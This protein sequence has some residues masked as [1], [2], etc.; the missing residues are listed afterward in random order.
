M[1]IN[2][3]YF[4][5]E[6]ATSFRRNWVMTFGGIA[7]I[8]LSLLLMGSALLMNSLVTDMVGDIESRINIQVWI[9]DN[10]EDV[11]IDGLQTI[12]Q[13]TENVQSVHLVSKDE[14][15]QRFTYMTQDSPEI[16]EQ[17]QGNPLPRSLEIELVDTQDID[18]VLT[19]IRN[20]EQFPLVA[21]PPADPERALSYG[22]GIVESLLSATQTAR[23]AGIALVGILAVVSLIFINNTIRLAIYARRNELS[24]MRLVGASNGFIRAPFILEGILQALVGA[25]LAILVLLAIKSFAFPGLQQTLAFIQ[26]SF[27]NT[28]M[29]H[30]ALV[31]LV[32][33]I[34]IG[35]LGAIIAMRKYLKI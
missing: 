24:I 17:L 33:G 1:S 35:A 34:I 18:S 30:I 22:Q 9:N 19:V 10:A 31:L 2:V 23:Y 5:S 20:S 11:D 29:T 27:T 26:F 25:I 4:I 28:L 32:S 16:V 15:L 8:F 21:D 13:N 14:A 6:A 12:L 3:G 7:T